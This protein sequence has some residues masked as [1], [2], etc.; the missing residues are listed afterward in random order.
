MNKDVKKIVPQ[1]R[2]SE[3]EKE[4][5]WK[6]KM[7]GDK[8][9]SKIVMGSSPKSANYNTEGKGLPLIQGNADIKNRLSVPRI[10]T[11]E[12]TK[13]CLID[14]ILL[15]VRAPVGTVAKSLH[16]A[17][18]GRGISAIR[19]VKDNSQEYLYQW[20]I[21][22]EPYWQDI[23][24]GG[25]F[26]AVNSDDIKKVS[27][28]FPSPKEQQKIADCFSSLDEVITA[29]TE[30]LDLLQDHKKG[31]LQQLFPAEGESQP[32]FRFPEFK[33]DGDW[34]ETTLDEVA[35][36]ENGK[37]HEQ[38]ISDTGKYKVVNSK[39][40]STEGEVVKFTDSANLM[41]NTGD[42]LMVLSDIPNGKAIAKCFYVDEDDTYTVNQRICKI[43]PTDIDNKF[44]FYIQNR[45]KYFLAFDDGVKQTNLRKE[46]ALSFPFLKPK[47]PKEQEKIANCL[48]LADDLIKKQADKIESLQDHKK[49][50]LQ[51]LFP[52]IND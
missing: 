33:D 46:T 9:V 41:A 40:I 48:T 6:I 38:E 34:E 5:E 21:S 37:A 17:C 1:L 45:N 8:D 12:I 4:G 24:Q 3:F 22:Y 52:S 7:L 28:P 13:E 23:S 43:T 20:L 11:S 16:K 18:I 36:Y 19:T 49:G 35:D 25:A 50:L 14:D 42:I 32:K 44:L 10:F 47:D 27:I 31:L 29:E 39:F 2:F 51:Q 26:D 15:S 30:K